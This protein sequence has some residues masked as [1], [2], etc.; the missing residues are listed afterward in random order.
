MTEQSGT[1]SPHEGETLRG[2]V[3][4]EKVEAWD[5]VK[6]DYQVDPGGEP[7]PNSM[8][9][10]SPRTSDEDANPV[11]DS[12]DVPVSDSAGPEDAVAS[13]EDA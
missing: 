7:V 2:G 6:A 11:E 12:A 9:T 10:A 13:E 3:D 8:D 1:N 4:R 5:E